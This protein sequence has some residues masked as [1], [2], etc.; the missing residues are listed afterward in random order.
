MV[1]CAA[2]QQEISR[3]DSLEHPSLFTF[4]MLAVAMLQL[5]CSHSYCLI[6]SS[7]LRSRFWN[8][9][10]HAAGLGVYPYMYSCW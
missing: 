3:C 8:R 2:S 5:P 1:L 4:T 10:L 6:I 7:R 9:S